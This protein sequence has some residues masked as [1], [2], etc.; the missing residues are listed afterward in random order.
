MT[1]KAVLSN[2]IYYKPSESELLNI[3]KQL[4]YRIESKTG[5]K[6]RFNSI[7]IIRNYKS[8]P[9]GLISVPQGRLDL[10][11]E[12]IEVVDKRVI[13]PVPFPLPKF[14]L[15]E[16]QQEVFD[17]V[18]DSCFINAPVG[19]GKTF[20]AL[21][22]ARKLGQRT[23]VVTHTTMLRDQWIEEVETLFGMKAGIIGSGKFDIEDCAIVIGN[24]QSVTKLLPDINKEFG[25]LILDEAHHVPA[26]TFSSLVDGMYCRYR[27]A[28]SGTMLRTDGKH[29][30]FKDYF[31]SKIIKPPQSHTMNPIVKLVPSGIS[32]P[33]GLPWAK[34]INHLLYDEDYQRF[35][36]SLAAVQIHKGHTVL[37]VADRVEFLQNV[38]EFIGEDCI[39]ITGETTFEERKNLIEQVESGKKSCIAGSRQI[40]SEGISVNVLSSV[41][42]ASPGANPITLE[43]IIGRIMRM[44]PGKQTPE[45]LDITFSSA[46]EKRQGSTRLA[47]YVS[48]GWEVRKL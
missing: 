32:L 29:I 33:S 12:G 5:V 44:S 40:F 46:A 24:V 13:H 11:P 23:L 26:D 39:L 37:I 25:T 15:R 18:E 4:T 20:T 6:G 2:R 9:Q 48:K 8:L 35:I 34:K 43:Q 3:V 42:L 38:K 30:I 27:I 31:G 41:V 36:A 19:W 1:Q 7:E 14:P 16:G 45:V 22:I 10:L 47:F 21:H 17:E 28:L